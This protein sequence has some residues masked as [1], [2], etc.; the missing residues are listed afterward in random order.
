[1]GKLLVAIISV[2]PTWT[3]LGL[4][5]TGAGLMAR[6]VYGLKVQGAES[7][8]TSFWLGWAFTLLFLQL[9]HLYLPVDGRALALVG[10]LG[11]AGLLWSRQDL[12]ALL[13]QRLSGKYIPF[14]FLLLLSALWIADHAILLP[15][16]YDSGLY[17]LHAVRWANAY[18]LVPGLGNLH[19]R[20]AFNSSYF[21]Y[22]S[23]LEVGPWAQKSQHLA[24]G[25]LLWVLVAQVL[26]CG[27][28]LIWRSNPRL[29]VYYLFNVLLLPAALKMGAH[30]FVASPSPDLPI[31][32]LGMVVAAALL[33]FLIDREGDAREG[34]YALWF[35]TALAAAGITV[36]LNFLALGLTA[37]IL[38]GVIWFKR[39]SGQVRA[40]HR[41]VV[42]WVIMWGTLVLLPWMLRG[43]V[44][45]GY[46]AFPLTFGSLQVEWRMPYEQVV[47]LDRWIRSWTRAPGLDAGEVLGNWQWLGPWFSNLFKIEESL[48]NLVTP[49]I[50]TVVFGA[51]AL[52][53]RGG[54][55]GK[56][57]G[58]GFAWVFLLCPAASI[59]VWF[60]T[61]PDVRLVGASFWIL[62]AGCVA[63]SIGSVEEVSNPLMSPW[64]VPC[65]ALALCLIFLD[66]PLLPGRKRSGD[67]HEIARVELKTFVTRSGLMVYTPKDG[68]Q[69]WDAPLPCTPYPQADLRL[70]RAGDLGSGFRLDPKAEAEAAK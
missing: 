51:L 50:L 60:F 47:Q 17:H 15:M 11:L 57:A 38:A 27:F 20:L 35:I 56:W 14:F 65:L 52:Y 5:F 3:A 40:N 6:R 36:K 8:L 58:P 31:F 45:S 4:I 64:F 54:Q 48:V 33:K 18:P 9:W 29:E 21:L 23:L 12:W 2:I 34:G 67:F 55:R 24:N 59:L 1:M 53:Y 39:F 63:L 49:V 32:V 13:T 37:S 16:F 22:V 69:C 30:F 28:K 19:H 25:L 70:R 42:V 44:T 10:A 68:G 62:A 46:I 7:L 43:V 41:Y 61:A 26:L 66:K